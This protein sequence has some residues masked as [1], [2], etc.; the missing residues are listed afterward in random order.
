MKKNIEFETALLKITID[1]RS[2]RIMLAVFC[3]VAVITRFVFKVPVPFLVLFLIFIWFLLYFVYAYLI[4]RVKTGQ[5]LYNLY[6]KYN[7][8]D[9]LFLTMIIHYLGGV[10]WIGVIFYILV[11][12]MAGVILPKKKAIMLGFVSLFFYSVLV[13]LEYF[14][15]IPHNPIFL[16]EPG[17]YQSSAYVATSILVVAAFFYFVA[18]TAGTFSEVL[19]KRTNELERAYQ[20]TEEAREILEIRVEARTKELQE[21]VGER[22]EIIKSRTKELQEKIQEL[23]RFQRLAVGRE[24]KM[25]ELKKEIK[26]L[27]ERS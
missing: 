7:I 3:I 5:G 22:E 12:V 1:L 16:L 14:G 4:K 10:A 21:L 20:Q 19:R 26:E 2:T 11:L 13:F 18:E 8:G 15:I 9:I 23:E 27:Q 17:L 24:L 25:I 6:F